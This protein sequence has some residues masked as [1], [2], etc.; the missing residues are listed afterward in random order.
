V[1]LVSKSGVTTKSGSIEKTSAPSETLYVI[2]SDDHTC[3]RRLLVSRR[4]LGWGKLS[5][6]ANFT[7]RFSP[8]M[9]GVARREDV[10]ARD[11]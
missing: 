9:E 3:A 2:L 6:A 10:R 7:N 11:L 4:N 8:L 1:T 5:G